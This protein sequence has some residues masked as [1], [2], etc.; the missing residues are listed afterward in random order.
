M[1]VFGNSGLPV[2]LFPAANGRYYQ[3]KDFGLIESVKDF[4]NEG[5]VKIYCPDTI[6]NESWFNFNI[7]PRERIERQVVYEKLIIDEVIGFAKY[8]TETEKVGIAGCDLGAYQAVNTAFKHPEYFSHIITMGG[9]FDIKRFIFGFYDEQCYY[10]SP[11][12]YLP[13]LKDQKYLNEINNIK[14][15]VGSGELD[16]NL[17]ENKYFSNL[18]KEK[19]FFHRFDVIPNADHD[20]PWWRHMFYYFIKDLE[21]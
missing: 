17:E 13:E 18:L 4:V 15:M 11:L 16:L 14:I 5:K 3:T 21:Y 8:E 6:D 10:N 12:D 19:N 2:I 7:E 20:W 1:L 9:S